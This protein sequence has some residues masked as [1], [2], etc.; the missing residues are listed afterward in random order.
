MHCLLKSTARRVTLWVLYDSEETLAAPIWPLNT[1]RFQGSK[2]KR[3]LLNMSSNS[4]GKKRLDNL[5]LSLGSYHRAW[6]RW[7]HR[8]Q[9]ALQVHLTE[10]EEGNRSLRKPST[11]HAS[12]ASWAY[13]SCA[14]GKNKKN[15]TPKLPLCDV[16]LLVGLS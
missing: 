3:Q 15:K 14:L 10:D 4:L 7:I 6:H 2:R 5:P 13:N 12:K 9:I 8:E 16:G 11:G 1:M